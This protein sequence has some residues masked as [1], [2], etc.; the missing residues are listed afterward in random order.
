MGL[1][2]YTLW[3]LWKSQWAKQV[4]EILEQG[5][6]VHNRE[7]HAFWETALGMLLEHFIIKH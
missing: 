2:K 4:A 5:Q 3:S 7:I 1:E 6:A